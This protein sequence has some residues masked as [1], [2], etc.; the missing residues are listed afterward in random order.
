MS[1]NPSQKVVESTS[2][3]TSKMF[4]DSAQ[5]SRNKQ[6]AKDQLLAIQLMLAKRPIR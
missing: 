2:R 6:A 1:H 4:A 5:E 3:L